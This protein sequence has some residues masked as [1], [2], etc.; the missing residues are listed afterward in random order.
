MLRIPVLSQSALCAAV[1]ATLVLVGCASTP[2]QI[3][4][5][6]V[7]RLSRGSTPFVAPSASAATSAQ[8]VSALNAYLASARR[9][10]DHNYGWQTF[11]RVLVV[12][13]KG[14][15]AATSD[16]ALCVFLDENGSAAAIDM[17]P[18]SYFV[19]P[20]YVNDNTAIRRRLSDALRDAPPE[21]QKVQAA[22][23]AAVGRDG[24]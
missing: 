17:A 23:H 2:P 21:K 19:H 15:A 1:V 14:E 3:E 16:Y 6:S 12:V 4:Q 8:V 7:V 20:V 22:G 5:G 18:L 11:P 24:C 13:A 9:V 10:K